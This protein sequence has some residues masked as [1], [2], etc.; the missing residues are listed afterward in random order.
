MLPGVFGTAPAASCRRR[1]LRSYRGRAVTIGLLATA[2]EKP[3]AAAGV[4]AGAAA[5]TGGADARQ[6]VAGAIKGI[7]QPLYGRPQLWRRSQ[8]GRLSSAQLLRLPRIRLQ[9]AAASERDLL[10]PCLLPLLLLLR[11]PLLPLA[12]MAALAA[13]LLPLRAYQ[14]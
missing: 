3:R 11:P 9:A 13:L 7:P 4:A 1:Q 2:L 5:I 6:E 12:L 10:R 8:V 14:R